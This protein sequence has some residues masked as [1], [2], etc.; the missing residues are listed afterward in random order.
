MYKITQRTVVPTGQSTWQLQMKRIAKPFGMSTLK[1]NLDSLTLGDG[2]DR[3]L[4]RNV[5]NELPIST[6]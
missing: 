2:V 3:L 4:R 1:N 6:A 5:G